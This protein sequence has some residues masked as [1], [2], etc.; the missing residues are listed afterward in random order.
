MGNPSAQ[1]ITHELGDAGEWVVAIRGIF[2][3]GDENPPENARD[4]PGARDRG[5][6]VTLSI[7]QPSSTRRNG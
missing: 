6:G 7:H 2:V 4:N 3:T 1:G 5:A